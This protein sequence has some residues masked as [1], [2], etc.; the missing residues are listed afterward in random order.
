MI[1]MSKADHA[2]LAVPHNRMSND[3]QVSYL[4]ADTRD[5]RLMLEAQRAKQNGIVVVPRGSVDVRGFADVDG[6]QTMRT[7]LPSGPL[8][9][10]ATKPV[11]I[12]RE[13][14]SWHARHDIVDKMLTPTDSML[15]VNASCALY[16]ALMQGHRR[17][18]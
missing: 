11:R 14:S 17:S 12:P 5:Y 13:R 6:T 3:V 4:K 8:K 2:A 10:E 9:P 7:P 1:T 18:I 16:D 15:S